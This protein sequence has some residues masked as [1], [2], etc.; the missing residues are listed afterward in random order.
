MAAIGTTTEIP[1]LKL[2]AKGRGPVLISGIPGRLHGSLAFQNSTAERVTLKSISIQAPQLLGLKREPLDAVPIL[3]R[4]APNASANV[5]FEF[6]ID[7][8]TPPG[9]YVA[10]ISV[11][12][13]QHSAQIQVDDHVELEVRPDAVTLFADE[14]SKY[15]FDLQLTNVGNV[16]LPLGENWDAVMMPSD[17]AEGMLLRA[18]AGAVNGKDKDKTR[19]TLDEVLLACSRQC[20]GIAKIRWDATNLEA[21]ETHRVG[22]T[23][24][25]P[26][27]LPRDRH[28]IA[29]LDLYSAE[30]R[31][32]IYTRT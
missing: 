18:L 16:A 31:I 13:E 23:I 7:P 15:E 2:L 5:D 3:G 20:P 32:D 27:G 1:G 24:E 19:P 26:A 8:A 6:A 30:L 9:E 14:K 22:A 12:G 17:G 4:L 10:T 29:K 25:L 21:G 11:G 28:F